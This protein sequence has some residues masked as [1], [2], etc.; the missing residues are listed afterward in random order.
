VVGQDHDG[1]EGVD[2]ERTVER[3]MAGIAEKIVQEDEAKRTQE[4]VRPPPHSLIGIVHLL[5][6]L[7]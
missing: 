4:L 5:N 3:R 7:E 1:E 6:R 2:E